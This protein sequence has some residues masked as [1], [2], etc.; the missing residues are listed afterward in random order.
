MYNCST[1]CSHTYQ[2]IIVDNGRFVL[3]QISSAIILRTPAKSTLCTKV[4]CLHWERPDPEL[5]VSKLCGS[6]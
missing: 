3:P 4:T 1:V 6:E 5:D 2:N